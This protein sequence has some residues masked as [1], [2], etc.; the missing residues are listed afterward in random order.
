MKISL[1]DNLIS[2][3]CVHEDLK[4]ENTVIH[5]KQG[6]SFVL[7]KTDKS[8]VTTLPHILLDFMQY[9]LLPDNVSFNCIEHIVRWVLYYLFRNVVFVAL[10]AKRVCLGSGFQGRGQGVIGGGVGI[11]FQRISS[12]LVFGLSFFASVMRD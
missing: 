11:Q 1:R 10:A 6:T 2:C 8:S 5:K 4:R 9:F 7:R 3:N 12:F